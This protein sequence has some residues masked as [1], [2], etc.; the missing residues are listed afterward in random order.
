M[1][2][3]EPIETINKPLYQ[4]G[5]NEGTLCVEWDPNHPFSLAVGTSLKW[6]KFYDTRNSSKPFRSI[7]AHSKSVQ[8]MFF[9]LFLF[10]QS[11]EFKLGGKKRDFCF[12][13]S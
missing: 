9:F 5:S 6:L 13:F 3:S 7:S 8:G 10:F 12:F 11:L 4:F 1:E 2:D